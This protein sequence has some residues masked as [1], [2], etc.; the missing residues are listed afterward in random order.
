MPETVQIPGHLRKQKQ[1]L[2]HN[3][4]QPI[5]K[6]Q[7]VLTYVAEPGSGGGCTQLSCCRRARF[8]SMRARRD[9]NP[10]EGAAM[11]AQ[12]SRNMEARE[13]AGLY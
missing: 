8:S 5:E 12:R 11:I 7:D 2:R 1:R 3:L 13:A 4:M 9:R 10:E 6:T